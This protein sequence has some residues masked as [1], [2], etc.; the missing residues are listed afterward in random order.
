MVI[1]C[2]VDPEG[3]GGYDTEI[4]SVFAGMACLVGVLIAVAVLCK[5]SWFGLYSLLGHAW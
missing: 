2:L 3:H 4:V 5:L 1:V